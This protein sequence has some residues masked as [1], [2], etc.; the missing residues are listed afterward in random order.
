MLK[1]CLRGPKTKCSTLLLDKM[2]QLPFSCWSLLLRC[3]EKRQENDKKCKSIQPKAC[4]SSQFMDSYWLEPYIMVYKCA[5]LTF[6]RRKQFFGLDDKELLM[7][8]S[9]P[10]SSFAVCTFLTPGVYHNPRTCTE[11]P[12]S[13]TVEEQTSFNP[14][15][16]YCRA[17]ESLGDRLVIG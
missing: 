13:S 17:D 3:M 4:N 1:T 14:S 12:L 11:K 8:S 7:F 5:E 9:S 10:T 15:A 16:R 6:R 2:L